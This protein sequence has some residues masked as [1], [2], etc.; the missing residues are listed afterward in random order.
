MFGLLLRSVWVVLDASENISDI[1]PFTS[2]A[3]GLL[4]SLGRLVTIS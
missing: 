2:G 4:L 3:W 1:W